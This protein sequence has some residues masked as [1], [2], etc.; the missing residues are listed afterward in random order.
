MFR[1]ACAATAATLAIVVCPGVA[2]AQTGQDVTGSTGAAQIGSVDGSPSAGAN[3]PTT[4]NAPVS[5]LSPNSGGDATRDGDTAAAAS[6]GDGSSGAADQD[7]SGSSGAAQIGSAGLSPA[8]AADAPATVN[9]PVTVASPDSG[10]D[11]SQTGDTGS[12][13]TAGGDTAAGGDQTTTGSTGALQANPVGLAP[14]ARVEAPITGNT[15]ITIL[16][17][18]SGGRRHDDAE[19]RYAHRPGRRHARRARHGR[20]DRAERRCAG[21]A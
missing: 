18:D 8:V 17:P 21:R 20:A 5:V 4:V 9:A 1:R 19:R 2:S 16:S 6:S 14:T 13:A 11:A 10:G 3:A 12:S 7:V 15:P